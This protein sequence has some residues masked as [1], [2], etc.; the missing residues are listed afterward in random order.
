MVS[1]LQFHIRSYFHPR[2]L[3]CL[4]LRTCV[5][6]LWM[7]QLTGSF[8][9]VMRENQA[10]QPCQGER[11]CRNL[12]G[13]LCPELCTDLMAKAH[14][15]QPREAVPGRFRHYVCSTSWSGQVRFPKHEPSIVESDARIRLPGVC[16]QYEIAEP[17]AQKAD[18]ANFSQPFPAQCR[19]QC[20]STHMAEGRILSQTLSYSC[21]RALKGRSCLVTRHLLQLFWCARSETE[22]QAPYHQIAGS[23]GA[24]KHASEFEDDMVT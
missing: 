18:F 7:P 24:R 9:G 17:R 15:A 22:G 6:F 14:L 12:Q 8:K 11:S 16:M 2:L 4:R 21:R 1:P 23:S 19:R 5:V 10:C 13:C 3:S 20:F